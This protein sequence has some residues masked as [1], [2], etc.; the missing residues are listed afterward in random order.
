MFWKL[1]L[2]GA[3][4]LGRVMCRFGTMDEQIGVTV[5]RNGEVA[6]LRDAVAVLA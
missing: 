2:G 5:Y 4:L 3:G 1:G 6:E